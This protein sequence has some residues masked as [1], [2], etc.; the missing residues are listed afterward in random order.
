MNQK[1]YLKSQRDATILQN[2]AW[3][4]FSRFT[5]SNITRDRSCSLFCASWTKRH[6]KY[7]SPFGAWAF[8]NLLKIYILVICWDFE[9][10]LVWRKSVHFRRVLTLTQLLL[11]SAF[12]LNKS[13]NGF[14][15]SIKSKAREGQT[16]E[17]TD[18][19]TDGVLHLMR[20][21]CRNIVTVWYSTLPLCLRTANL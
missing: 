17:E 19:Q 2:V 21:L 15:I 8:L 18:R 16:E 1:I 5:S 7:L 13:F 10:D 20:P 14:P 4:L 12:P 11:S 3:G 6:T 9:N